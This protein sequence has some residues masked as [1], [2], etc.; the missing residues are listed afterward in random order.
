[1]LKNASKFCMHIC[2]TY[3]RPEQ[4][5]GKFCIKN[6]KLT[7]I[8]NNMLV[9]FAYIHAKFSSLLFRT[10]VSFVFICKMQQSLFVHI[11]LFDRE[12]SEYN[13]EEPRSMGWSCN[14]KDLCARA[15]TNNSSSRFENIDLTLSIF[16]FL[17]W[18]RKMRI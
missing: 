7:S 16:F 8:L 5:A 9:S 11:H 1:M 17:G 14:N 2:K 4:Y 3:Q 6:A 18:V 10:L 15:N 13:R 12:S